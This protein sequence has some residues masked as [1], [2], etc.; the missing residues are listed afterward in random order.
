MVEHFVKS[1][2]REYGAIVDP[3]G[4]WHVEFRFDGPWAGQTKL[5]ATEPPEVIEVPRDE[6]GPFTYRRAVDVPA[7]QSA[8]PVRLIYDPDPSMDPGLKH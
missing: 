1:G 7:W 3:E 2:A 5:F 8:K 4:R 6:G